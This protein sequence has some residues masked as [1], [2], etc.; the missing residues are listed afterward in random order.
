MAKAY[1][2]TVEV[3]SETIENGLGYM[4]AFSLPD[5][6]LQ[7]AQLADFSEWSEKVKAAVLRTGDKV[8]DPDPYTKKLAI[9]ELMNTFSELN[10]GYSIQ[11]GGPAGEPTVQIQSTNP[12]DNQIDIAFTGS[13]GQ[14]Q[15]SEHGLHD[16]KRSKVDENGRTSLVEGT[17]HHFPFTKT[18]PMAPRKPPQGPRPPGM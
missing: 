1:C 16:L 18:V 9:A 15:V 10:E 4:I 7:P 8:F 3:K 2:L 13:D 5:D 12:Y 14:F 11:I 6:R 17:P